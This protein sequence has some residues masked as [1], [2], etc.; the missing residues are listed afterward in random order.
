MEKYPDNVYQ[1]YEII[2]K[3][4]EDM[5]N[6]LDQ[7][8]S[9]IQKMFFKINSLANPVDEDGEELAGQA[10]DGD[11]A[12]EPEENPQIFWDEKTGTWTNQKP[13][14]EELD[15]YGGGAG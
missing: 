8:K 5:E 4:T 3:F 10:L 12:A 7:L 11:A 15:F 14:G 9:K 2:L 13:A 6:T 1:M